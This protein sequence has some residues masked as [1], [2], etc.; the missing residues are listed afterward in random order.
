VSRFVSPS[1]WVPRDVLSLERAAF[2]VVRST[3]NALIVA[4]PGAGKTETL[5]QR[6]SFLLETHTCAHPYRILAISFKR[7]AASNL[8]DRVARRCGSNLSNRFES[9]TFDAWAKSLLDRFLPALPD[10]YRPTGNY[11]LDWKVN[12][13]APL[14]SRL[15]AIGPRI[16][17]SPDFVYQ[18]R[19]TEFYR[20]FIRD[21]PLSL[22]P[23]DQGTKLALAQEVWRDLL[24]AGKRS[25]LDFAM[26]GAL[27]ELILRMNPKLV[28]MI[29]VTYRYLFLDEFQDTTGNQF[30]LLTTAFLGS[31][32]VISAVGDNKQRIMLWAGAKRDVFEEFKRVFDA[33][34]FALH[35]NYRSAPNLIAI[36]NHLIEQMNSEQDALMQPPPGRADGGECKIFVFSDEADEAQFLGKHISS[37]IHEDG[38]PASQIS[39]LVRQTPL[40]YVDTLKKS[41][42]HYGV[43][44]RAQDELQDLL[45]EPLTKI[46]INFVLVISRVSV[47]DAWIALREEVME[48]KG[49]DSE[50]LKARNAADELSSFTQAARAQL[51]DITSKTELRSFLLALISF[52]GESSFRQ[53]HERYLQDDFFLKTF[54]DCC[55]ALF[56]SWSRKRSWSEAIED[57]IGV[58]SVPVMSIHKSKGLEFHTVIFMGLEDFPFRRGLAEK[59][60]EEECNVFV[61][62]SRAK[63]RVIITTVDERF[64]YSQSRD[65]VR[66]FFKVFSAAG[67]KATR[68]RNT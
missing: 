6:A 20:D 33:K 43:S 66:K 51:I 28:E 52:L 12:N 11:L 1:E 4:G 26:I 5:A 50:S 53:R 17:F 58:D 38:V 29:Q 67:V 56:E 13:D 41:L 27:A 42:S 57:F 25:V 36:Q 35:T 19:T 22:N 18:L 62:F 49:Y 21:S 32:T 24:F 14:Q 63:E 45:A 16:G 59:N 15:L 2:D 48:L 40:R 44:I 64:G 55:N 68:V 10:A 65:G 37:W 61:A 60:G 9:Y 30:N 46:I 3:K 54:E 39:I 34:P 7:D 23:A 47:P 8:K 31:E